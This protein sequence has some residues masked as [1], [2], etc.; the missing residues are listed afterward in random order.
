MN[1][2][3]LETNFKD[4]MDQETFYFKGMEECEEFI[5][6]LNGHLCF[7]PWKKPIE[8]PISKVPDIKKEYLNVDPIKRAEGNL[9]WGFSALR[10]HNIDNSEKIGK[11]VSSIMENIEIK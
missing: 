7:I 5:K 11:I 9:S 3:K 1:V 10:F 2:V 8:V 4:E 6:K